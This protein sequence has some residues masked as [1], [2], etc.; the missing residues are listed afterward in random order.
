M[1]RVRLQT[2]VT[3]VEQLPPGVPVLAQQPIAVVVQQGI[4]R[5]QGLRGLLR[6]AAWDKLLEGVAPDGQEALW[7]ERP[8]GLLIKPRL[9]KPVGR[10]RRLGGKVGGVVTPVGMWRLAVQLQGVGRVMALG[11]W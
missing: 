11:G 6:G 7:L 10:Q 3:R 8:A 9:V 2:P 5:R 4:G 1:H